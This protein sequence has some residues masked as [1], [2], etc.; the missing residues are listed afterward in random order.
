MCTVLH[1]TSLLKLDIS[2]QENRLIYKLEESRALRKRNIH[3][4]LFPKILWNMVMST[5]H[6]SAIAVHMGVNNMCFKVDI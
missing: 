3:I 2:T 1:G 5:C 6:S 4:W